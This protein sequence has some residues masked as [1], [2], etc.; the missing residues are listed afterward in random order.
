MIKTTDDFIM[1]IA[2]YMGSISVLL[3][4]L[5]KILDDQPSQKDCNYL[6][7]LIIGLRN[8]MTEL[9]T[10]MVN[11][12]DS[13][14][15]CH[16]LTEI[17]FIEIRQQLQTLL[18]RTK[19][20]DACIQKDQL[21]KILNSTEVTSSSIHGENSNLSNITNFCKLLS[22]EIEEQSILWNNDNISSKDIKEVILMAKRSNAFAKWFSGWKKAVLILTGLGG[23]ILV[24]LDKVIGLLD[25]I[26][27]LR[28]TINF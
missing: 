8:Q 16:K 17:S 21:N 6:R 9:F 1:E 12:F 27:A 5:E 18:D 14:A 3:S 26:E 22:K 11:E 10:K 15:D 20:F 24:Y 25:F 28:K 13:V 23:V 2:R 7:E 4:S 19:E